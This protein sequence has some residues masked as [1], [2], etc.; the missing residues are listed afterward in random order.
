MSSASSNSPNSSPNGSPN[1]NSP[2]S[3]KN[4][5]TQTT[6]FDMKIELLNKETDGSG[7]HFGYLKIITS[8]FPEG[9]KKKGNFRV[10][11]SLDVSSSMREEQRLALAKETISKLVEFLVSAS[12]ENPELH[13][14]LTLSTFSTEARVVMNN[15]KVYH[16]TERTIIAALQLIRTENSTNFEAMFQLDRQTMQNQAIEDAAAAAASGAM[17]ITTV[18]IVMTD[19]EITAG[20]KDENELKEML[21]GD[22][23][24]VFIG[25]G[26]GHN[27][28]CLMKLASVN[29]KSS[30]LFLD[31]PTK[32]GAMFAQ[33]FCPH[34][35]TSISDVEIELM[36]AKILD[37]ESGEEVERLNLKHIAADTTKTFHL[38]TD[39][40]FDSG[41]TMMIDDDE[42]KYRVKEINVRMQFRSY[43]NADLDEHPPNYP[44]W[45]SFSVI[46]ATTH[47]LDVQKER[48]RWSVLVL[49][50]DAKKL[51]NREEVYQRETRKNWFDVTHHF[52]EERDALIRRATELKDEIKEFAETNGIP[53]DEMLRDLTTD[54]VICI[55]A[56]PSNEHGLMYI[57]SRFRSCTDETPTAAS[58]L[59]PLDDHVQDFV[60]SSGYTYGDDRLFSCGG[61]NEEALHR[62]RSSGNATHDMLT[63]AM[64]QPLSEPSSSSQQSDPPLQ[65]HN[66]SYRFHPHPHPHPH[67]N[68]DN[69]SSSSDSSHVVL[70]NN[71]DDCFSYE[72]DCAPSR[73]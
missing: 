24:H 7:R 65:R 48:K 2:N 55:C 10:H 38:L 36:G 12:N 41:S 73:R 43:D 25:Y 18:H 27:A 54:L 35:F 32:M 19:G 29:D 33:I 47:S 72:D 57:N 70:A 44:F 13:F 4:D 8:P 15:V 6:P 45:K 17:P 40:R 11:I 46:S 62:R 22:V 59:T 39:P 52:K 69:D 1:G 34:L 26:T 23:E 53:D 58:D 16:A 3:P 5:P 30:Y 71:N 50:K 51:K 9:H 64:S 67:D 68:V 60:H 42:D 20:N 49:M 56:I 37:I 31:H 61:D 21:C 14:W 28:S 63:R 66:S